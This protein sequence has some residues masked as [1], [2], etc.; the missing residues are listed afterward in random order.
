MPIPGFERRAPA[1]KL[2][3]FHLLHSPAKSLLVAFLCALKL[4]DSTA[5]YLKEL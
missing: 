5:G 3:I 2:S 1:T 4:N